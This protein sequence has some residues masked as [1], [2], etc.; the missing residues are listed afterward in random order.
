MALGAGRGTVLGLVLRGALA[1]VALG[2]A[3]GIPVALAGGRLL[4]AELY[5]V[6]AHDP[7]ILALAAAI[8]GI[9]VK[10]GGSP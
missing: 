2:L 3:I 5:G 9:C 10:I 6:K 1:R 8:L 7:V 4:A